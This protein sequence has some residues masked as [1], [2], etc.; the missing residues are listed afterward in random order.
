MIPT[1]DTLMGLECRGA[2]PGVLIAP[3]VILMQLIL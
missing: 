1:P 3:E 2:G